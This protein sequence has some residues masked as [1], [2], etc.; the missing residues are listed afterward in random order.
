[1]G[2]FP[3][4]DIARKHRY[5]YH[6]VPIPFFIDGNEHVLGQSDGHY[7]CTLPECEFISKKRESIQK[8]VNVAH[9]GSV[10]I[11][12]FDTPECGKFHDTP[13]DHQV[14]LTSIVVASK[15][16]LDQDSGAHD[17]TENLICQS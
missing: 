5:R 12:V 9:N 17:G 11:K 4:C 3:T 6:S 13:S 8:H 1:V 10:K 16:V 7:S 14:S 2:P 15:Q